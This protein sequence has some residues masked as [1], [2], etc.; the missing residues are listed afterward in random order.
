[1]LVGLAN[2]H[3]L[4]GKDLHIMDFFDR[5]KLD[6]FCLVETWNKP[7]QTPQI[8][9]NF[10]NITKQHLNTNRRNK[11]GILCFA[12]TEIQKDIEI[13]FTDINNDYVIIKIHGKYITIIYSAPNDNNNNII[14][15][16]KKSK[17]TAGDQPCI[18]MGDLNARMGEKT[19]DTIYNTR[20]RILARYL[21]SNGITVWNAS[22][23]RFTSFSTNGLGE[24]NGQG[25]PDVIL[26][27]GEPCI[28]VTIHDNE[29]L[30]GSDH[31]PITFKINT[32]EPDKLPFER[33]NVRKMSEPCYSFHY[34]DLLKKTK[35]EV[36]L[37]L[38]AA[39]NINAAWDAVKRWIEKAAKEACGV[40]K[41]KPRIAQNFWTPELIALRDMVKDKT[42]TRL[43]AYRSGNGH[44]G[45]Y[46]VEL[47][48]ANLNTAMAARKLELFQEESN[49]LGENENS[50]AL[51]RMIKGR[52]ARAERSGC[53][54]DA[55]K[56]NEHAQHYLGTFGAHNNLDVE[57]TQFSSNE[58]VGIVWEEKQ[59]G[60]Q[61]KYLA[62]GKAAGID[63]IM[64]E[65]LIHGRKEMAAILAILFNRISK[66]CRIPD[67]W[68]QA[69]IVP[70]YKQKGDNRDI[71]NYRPI[72]LTVITRRL[73][74]RLLLEPLKGKERLLNRTQGGFRSQR[75]T[76]DH[77]YTLDE[78]IKDYEK[79]GIKIALMDLKAAFDTVDRKILWR[80]LR[81]AYNFEVS[82]IL[83]LQDLFDRN[84]SILVIK[85]RKSTPISNKRGL[86]Q[87]SS[88]S[89]YL[90]N[91]FIDS[92]LVELD[93]AKIH[94]VCKNI[95]DLAFADDIAIIARKSE[96][97]EK[98][99]LI[100]EK[101]SKL[102]GMEF[103]PNKCYILSN[104][105]QKKGK[106]FKIYGQKI[107]QVDSALYLGLPF[108]LKGIN[109]KE[110]IENR[111]KK[112]RN[113]VMM[114]SRYG[115]NLGGYP[116]AAS[117]R[118][119]KTFI[120]AGL[121]YGTCLNILSQSML[122]PLQKIQNIALRKI[123]TAPNSTSIDGMHKL[124]NVEPFVN[125]QRLL[126]AKFIGRI[127]NNLDTSI[128]A[129]Q[130]FRYY[131]NRAGS[132][133]MKLL[134]NPILLD[135][136]YNLVDHSMQSERIGSRLEPGIKIFKK[137]DIVKYLSK[138]LSNLG[139]KEV[140]SISE[141][142]SGPPVS[143]VMK[144]RHCLLANAFPRG[145]IDRVPVFR[146][147]TGNVTRH[148]QCKNCNSGNQQIVT[149]ALTRKHGLECSGGLLL[150]S[151]SFPKD[152]LE[153]MNGIGSSGLLR[154][155]FL[156]FL[157][158]KYLYSVPLENFYEILSRAI[159]LI[160]V[161]CMAF[162]QKENG[163][164]I[165]STASGP[166]S[167]LSGSRDAP[168]SGNSGTTLYIARPN[169]P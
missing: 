71:S 141:T 87:G 44:L 9:N 152:Y 33:V 60:N 86:L 4:A 130:I 12:R 160:Y 23:G 91:F 142:I 81:F 161:K 85:G 146:W 140:G 108:T 131:K 109:H 98:L 40:I 133:G 119:Y 56:I 6:L 101:W 116:Q 80:R 53:L 65:F 72:A 69:L 120:R 137:S 114:L 132:N 75:S 125:R 136:P 99:L 45:N 104:E 14:E 158:N 25:V 166:S 38:A 115:M 95:N 156:D 28:E 79:S 110:N 52:K 126:A 122:T 57:E 117:V 113:T 1:M 143:G 18:I 59:I 41:Y 97:L 36:A 17:E 78:I 138:I 112:M 154:S 107:A 35:Q 144:F 169:P 157:L 153:F 67:E 16:I 90:F 31:H 164:Y 20:G 26:S 74:E 123:L 139:N 128:P 163:Y 89:P 46:G 62:K 3:G 145:V 47:A 51:M 27:T 5:Q 162:E 135:I 118:L 66:E 30:G 134:K 102:N 149:N 127:N 77:C 63:G 88:L 103:N 68:T 7:Q 73:Y 24:I 22:K 151:S 150:L 155:T 83:R 96:G 94:S 61:L 34:N 111:A 100:S 11:G 129:V 64:A 84:S 13:I 32:A 48:V 49:K 29:V 43:W 121:E 10:I 92:L 70:V 8:H 82:D 147:I 19:N 37:E 58:Y 124:L 148:T 55:T 105:T 167:G 54:L 42:E 2:V 76:L 165:S 39:L 93:N 159:G 168:S 50:G 106:E 15:A 21:D